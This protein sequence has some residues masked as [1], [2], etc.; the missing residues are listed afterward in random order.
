MVYVLFVW[1]GCGHGPYWS[2]GLFGPPC[3]RSLPVRNWPCLNLLRFNCLCLSR[4]LLGPGQKFLAIL[5]TCT[6]LQ[7]TACVYAVNCGCLREC[8][9]RCQTLAFSLFVPVFALAYPC[10]PLLTLSLFRSSYSCIASTFSVQQSHIHKRS[11]IQMSQ[12]NHATAPLVYP[13]TILTPWQRLPT[14]SPE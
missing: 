4:H 14:S 2:A 10:L 8:L 3:F 11:T 6:Q 1:L 12:C 9:L 13:T 7:K 5:M